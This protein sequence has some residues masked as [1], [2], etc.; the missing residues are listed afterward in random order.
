MFPSDANFSFHPQFHLIYEYMAVENLTYEQFCSYLPVSRETYG[1]LELYVSLLEKWQ[2]SINLI[3]DSTLLEMWKRHIIDSYQLV[4]SISLSNSVLDLGSGA[5]L[6][7][8]ILA[9]AGYNVALTESDGK[10]VAFLREAARIL[11][12]A[13]TIHHQRVE[14][15]SLRDASI[16]TARAFASVAAILSLLGGKLTSSHSLLLLK[17]KSYRDELAEAEKEHQFD[18]KIQPS[19]TDE[20]GVIVLL[21]NIK[22]RGV[23]VL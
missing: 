4:S 13:I 22:Q 9:V 1:K 23:K 5:G 16:I 11:G 14:E 20:S 18:V 3:S 7:G 17:G 2:K 12:L 6:P 19:I 15:V 21:Y 10:K 8:M